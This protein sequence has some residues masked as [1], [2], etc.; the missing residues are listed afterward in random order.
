MLNSTLSHLTKD[1]VSGVPPEA[2]QKGK[3]G[4]LTPVED[5]A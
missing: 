1:E 3:T 4:E 5:P 2:E